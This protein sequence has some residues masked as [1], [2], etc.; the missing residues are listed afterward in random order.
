MT[1]EIVGDLLHL[2]KKK[3]ILHLA[4][5]ITDRSETTI[6]I[7]LIVFLGFQRYIPWFTVY[8]GSSGR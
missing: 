6:D 8:W 4:C 3:E 2:P 5:I 1:F 7:E